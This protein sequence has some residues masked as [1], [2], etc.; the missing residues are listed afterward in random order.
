MT[1]RIGYGIKTE[2]GKYL[3]VEKER[4]GLD[5]QEMD[6]PEQGLIWDK[7]LAEDLRFHA[8]QQLGK[9]CRLV[10]FELREKE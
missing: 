10:V 3:V 1:I 8:Q 5:I 4:L 6:S 7:A 9:A 2:E